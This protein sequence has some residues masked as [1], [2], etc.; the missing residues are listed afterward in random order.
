M[1]GQGLKQYVSM[2]IYLKQIYSLAVQAFSTGCITG[3]Y[4]LALQAM[5]YPLLCRVGGDFQHVHTQQ[6]NLIL[7]RNK[8]MATSSRQGTTKSVSIPT[9]LY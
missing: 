9:R 2:A 4:G 6:R 5:A 1:N 3:V 7:L 8:S